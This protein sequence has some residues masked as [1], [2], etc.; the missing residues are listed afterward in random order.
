MER[1]EV[2]ELARQDLE[3]RVREGVKALFEQILEEE[4][5]QHLGAP[6]YQRAPTRRGQ[7]NGAHE[8]DL[9]TGVGT[10]QQLRVPRDREGTFQTE[11]FERYRR[12]T[13]SVEEAILGMYL[14]GVSTRKVAAVTEALSG[15]RVGRDAVSRITARLEEEVQA[16]RERKLEGEYPYLYLDATYLKAKWGGKVVSVALLVAVGVNAQGHRELLAVEAGSRGG[17]SDGMAES[18]AGASGSRP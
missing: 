10:I 15:R 6:R 1:E 12:M 14:Q 13:G 3:T 7:R 9:V 5:T 18:A 2:E 16:W 11:L 8:R 17:G 4:M